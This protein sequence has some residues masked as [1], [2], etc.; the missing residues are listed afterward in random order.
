LCIFMLILD[1]G[2]KYAKDYVEKMRADEV[3]LGC[4]W[5]FIYCLFHKAISSQFS[6]FN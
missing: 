5:G 3:E 6:G 2:L 1:S 4:F